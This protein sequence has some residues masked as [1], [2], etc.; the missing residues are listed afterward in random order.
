MS[1][2]KFPKISPCPQKL[3]P[4]H[5][6]HTL[7]TSPNFHPGPFPCTSP[8]VHRHRVR[9]ERRPLGLCSPGVNNFQGPFVV[10]LQCGSFKVAHNPLRALWAFLVYLKESCSC[11]LVLIT[12]T[13]LCFHHEVNQVR[14]PPLR[15]PGP[16]TE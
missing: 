7:I 10:S 12:F 11:L 1:Y 8:R 15:C 4:H 16:S 6:P 9:C 14:F 13:Y 3:P 2:S 5:L